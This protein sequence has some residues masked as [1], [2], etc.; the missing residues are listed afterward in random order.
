MVGGGGG[1]KGVVLVVVLLLSL[2]TFG[3][4]HIRPFWEPKS[5]HDN[6]RERRR[7]NYHFTSTTDAP[8]RVRPLGNPPLCLIHQWMGE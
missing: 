3:I 7:R 1:E 8:L 2:E 4:N 5:W 6:E